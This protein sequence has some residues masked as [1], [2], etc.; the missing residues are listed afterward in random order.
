MEDGRLHL[1]PALP[2][3]CVSPSTPPLTGVITARE[4]TLITRILAFEVLIGSYCKWQLIINSLPPSTVIIRGT[5][6]RIITSSLQQLETLFFFLIANIGYFILF[7]FF[8]SDLLNA[9]HND[10]FPFSSA[11]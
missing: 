4:E 2:S 1:P 8:L 11:S 7:I 9:E 3:R 10:E 5:E 6:G